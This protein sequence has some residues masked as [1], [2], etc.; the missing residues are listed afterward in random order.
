MKKYRAICVVMMICWQA[1]CF[2]ALRAD[3][4]RDGRVD[5]LDLAILASEWLMEDNDMRLGPELITNGGFSGIGSPWA[6]DSSGSWQIGDG[7]A[8]LHYEFNVDETHSLVYVDGNFLEGHTYRVTFEI[9]SISGNLPDE[10]IRIYIGT[11]ALTTRKT[12]AVFTEDIVPPVNTTY[13][14]I[15]PV[16]TV[17]STSTLIAVIDNVSVKEV[18]PD[19]D[20]EAA[21]LVFSSVL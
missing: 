6:L 18:F 3:I 9:K 13:L 8:N 1:V 20:D 17:P 7:Q 21:V 15:H 5:L 19:D 14:T 4:N 16:V 12:A 10:G 2:G 11:D